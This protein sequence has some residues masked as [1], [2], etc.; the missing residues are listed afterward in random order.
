M[1]SDL[2][3]L[4]PNSVLKSDVV[5]IGSGPAG[6]ALANELSSSKLQV[7]LVQRAAV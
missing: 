2:N 3:D 7:L 4:P 5:I 1:I 6:I